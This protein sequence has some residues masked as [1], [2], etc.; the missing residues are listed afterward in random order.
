MAFNK[1]SACC[2]FSL[3]GIF[4]LALPVLNLCSHPDRDVEF[5]TD[6]LFKTD[7]LEGCAAYALYI[8]GF[9][10]DQ[11]RVVVG[12]DGWLCLGDQYEYTLQHTR[13]IET[14]QTSPRRT[15]EIVQILRGNE[16]WMNAQGIPT[17]FVIAPDKYTL[18]PEFHPSWLHT[19]EQ[20]FTDHYVARA[21]AVGLR[22][23]DLRAGLEAQKKSGVPLFYKLDSH[24]NQYGAY[25][26]YRATIDRLNADYELGIHAIE[27]VEVAQVPI[28]GGGTSDLI[29]ISALLPIGSDV[30]VAVSYAGEGQRVRIQRM[31][32]KTHEFSRDV[33][34]GPNRNI[35]AGG[36]PYRIVNEDA[37]NDMR[38]LWIRDSFGN[39]NSRYYQ[40]TF[41]EIWSFHVSRLKGSALEDFIRREKP[42]LVLYQAVERSIHGDVLRDALPGSRRLESD[43]N[44]DV[45]AMR[46]QENPP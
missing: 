42:D 18:Y 21:D 36:P 29:K 1:K 4:A 32:P 6:F 20:R 27:D 15:N 19:P 46:V 9:S 12:R 16:E 39:N 3:T 17:L 14:P 13:G 26:G 11:Q 7:T 38:V 24:W 2:W 40:D 22:V 44:R 25:L 45:D 33:E 35:A 5:N 31:D 34:I 28:G 43:D 41:R 30:E 8:A 37:L 10:W 23:L